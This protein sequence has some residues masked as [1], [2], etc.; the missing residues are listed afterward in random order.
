MLS[1]RRQVKTP[2]VPISETEFQVHGDDAVYTF[3][4]DDANNVVALLW[5]N[6][7]NGNRLERV[8]E[9]EPIVAFDPN[10][11]FPWDVGGLY[12]PERGRNS[13]TISKESGQWKFK[14]RMR[15][16][17]PIVPVSETEFRVEGNDPVFAF[18]IDDASKVTA[19]IV[20]ANGGEFRLPR[21]VQ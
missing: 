15:G 3:E 2:L 14:D 11:T 8:P 19:V 18:E 21:V 17:L 12:K 13:I 20:K 1:A 9:R 5:Q 7:E 6:E 4:L 10:Y 16:L